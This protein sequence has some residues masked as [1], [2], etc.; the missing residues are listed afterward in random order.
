[1]TIKTGLN[2]EYHITEDEKK[3]IQSLDLR[4][5]G[6]RE[7]MNTAFNNRSL[8]EQ[9]KDDYLYVSSK[10]QQWFANFEYKYQVQGA[11]GYSWHVDFDTNTVNLKKISDN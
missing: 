6:I 10:F 11:D 4:K 9:L 2:A 1:M 7:L 5:K 3:E 8:Y